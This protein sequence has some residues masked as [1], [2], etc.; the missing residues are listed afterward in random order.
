MPLQTIS[1]DTV[2][3]VDT[4]SV[5]DELKT[6][7]TDVFTS[8]E[9]GGLSNIGS[10]GVPYWNSEDVISAV[11]EFAESHDNIPFAD[12]I[13]RLKVCGTCFKCMYTFELGVICTSG[14]NGIIVNMTDSCQFTPSRWTPYWE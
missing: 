5:L 3:G 10:L 9:L 11:D 12:D 8:K 13:E 14:D 7:L 4:V 2:L 1:L 6:H